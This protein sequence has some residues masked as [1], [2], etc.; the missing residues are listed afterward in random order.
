MTCADAAYK[1]LWAAD[2]PL[3]YR[4]VTKRIEKQGLWSSRGKTPAA[5]VDRD[6]SEE[7]NRRGK[8][9]RFCRVGHGVY[10]IASPSAKLLP[11]IVGKNCGISVCGGYT[12]WNS[13]GFR[14][15][16]VVKVD[17]DLA[18]VLAGWSYLK[19]PEQQQVVAIVSEAIGRKNLTHA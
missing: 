15:A 16:R 8:N 14:S 18:C 3:H 5:T 9:S 19:K 11:K 2:E 13:T 6:M 10:A 12:D 1:I 17:A 7:I 4:E